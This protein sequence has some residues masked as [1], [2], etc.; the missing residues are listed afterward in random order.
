MIARRTLLA[1]GLAGLAA[2]SAFAQRIRS[3]K[4]PLRL[5]VDSSLMDSG[6]ASALQQAFGRDTGVAVQLTG[7]ASLTLLDALERGEFDAALTNAPDA[8]LKLDKQGLVHDRQAIAD[9]SL[10]LVGP[11]PKKKQPDPAGVAGGKDIAAALVKIRDAALAAPGTVNFLAVAD[12]SGPHAAEQALWR[13]AQVAPAAPWYTPV[14]DSTQLIAQAR[15]AGAYALVERG[16]WARRGGA[17]LAVLV[18][19]DARLAVPVHVMRSF[20]VNHPAAKI[21]V[22]WIA[23][24]KGRRVVAGQRGYRTPA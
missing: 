19:G 14:M 12:G 15:T 22:A 5:A 6:L 3:L 18:D 7:G 20:R 16:V 17:P 2:S 4:D 1:G 23:G 9:G 24:P 8:E 21:F 13:A 10:V 11:A